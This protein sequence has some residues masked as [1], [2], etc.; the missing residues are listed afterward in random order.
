MR[1]TDRWRALGGGDFGVSAA[2]VWRDSEGRRRHGRREDTH[3][4]VSTSAPPQV[5]RTI[6]PQSCLLWCLQHL[7]VAS[8]KLAQHSKSNLCNVVVRIV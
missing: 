5:Q 1:S 8:P 7:S 6:H 4:R 3:A 2:V